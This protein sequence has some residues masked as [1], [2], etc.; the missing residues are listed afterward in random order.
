MSISKTW[1]VNTD[2]GPIICSWAKGTPK[3]AQ[4]KNTISDWYFTLLPTKSRLNNVRHFGM[5][6]MCLS[7][8]LNSMNYP[9]PLIRVLD[10][11]CLEIVL[12]RHFCPQCWFDRKRLRGTLSMWLHFLRNFN[13]KCDLFAMVLELSDVTQSCTGASGSS[14]LAAGLWVTQLCTGASGS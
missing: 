12:S 9:R 4:N 13:G 2:V 8:Q 5:N 1:N 3:S 10:S 14:A 7:E 6:T 11:A